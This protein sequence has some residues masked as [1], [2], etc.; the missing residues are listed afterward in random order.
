[1]ADPAVNKVE[2]P[3]LFSFVLPF[4]LGAVQGTLVL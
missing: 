1:M 2:R 3:L 4:V